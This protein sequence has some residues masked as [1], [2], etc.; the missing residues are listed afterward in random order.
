M[1]IHEAVL[2][3]IGRGR[4]YSFSFC[5]PCARLVPNVVLP[6]GKAI[7]TR[8]VAILAIFA[9]NFLVACGEQSAEHPTASTEHGR[10]QDNGDQGGVVS[11][12][13]KR[14]LPV[15]KTPGMEKSN[16]KRKQRRLNSGD[17]GSEALDQAQATG[18]DLAAK[19]IQASVPELKRNA[20]SA[21]ETEVV[22]AIRALEKSASVGN[23]RAQYQLGM[24]HVRG[25][26]SRSDERKGVEL[27]MIASERGH[28]GAMFQLGKLYRRGKAGLERDSKKGTKLILQAAQ[29]G[30]KRAA[31]FLEKKKQKRSGQ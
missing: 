3:V 4:I 11:L 31:K 1:T 20:L 26:Y 17:T 13:S 9:L 14:A 2:I 8:K 25:K 22:E 12:E 24:I 19:G 5:L 27:L 6:P 16:K 15:E 30:K 7:M 23:L 29:K 28:P 10:Q 21:A 18:S